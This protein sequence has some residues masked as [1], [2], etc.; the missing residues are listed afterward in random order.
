[1]NYISRGLRYVAGSDTSSVDQVPRLIERIKTSALPQDRRA[2][3]SK[4][5]QLAK[6]SPQRQVQVGELALKIIHAVLDQDKEYDETLKVTLDLLI[7]ICGTLDPPS[8]D[9]PSA[10]TLDAADIA[11]QNEQRI[12]DFEHASAKAAAT[13]VDM[14]LGLPNAALLIL[15]MLHNNDFYVKF[16]SIELLT[17]MAANSRETLQM[18]ILEAPQGVTRICDLLDD[19][20]RHVRSNAVLLLST[21]CEQSSEICKIIAYGGVLEKLFSLM[22]TLTAPASVNEFGDIDDEEDNLESAIVVQDVL[23]VLRNLIEGTKMTKTFLRDTGCLPR[24]VNVLSR[25]IDDSNIVSKSGKQPSAQIPSAGVKAAVEKQARKNLLIVIQCVSAIVSDADDETAQIKTELATTNLFPSLAHVVFGY[26]D[27]PDSEKKH[28]KG[29]VQLRIAALKTMSMLV[30]GHD[31]YRSI[32]SSSTYALKSEESITVQVAALRAMTKD[33]SSA[34]REAS[35][36]VLRESLTVDSALGLPSSTLLNALTG[37]AGSSSYPMSSVASNDRSSRSIS[38]NSTNIM[39]LAEELKAILVGWPE[40]ADASAVFYAASIISWVVERVQGAKERLLA[41]YVNGGALLPQII[42]VMGK[43]ER[44]QGPPEVRVALFSLACVWLHD[45][46]SAVSA[47]LSSAVH[48]PMLVEIITKTGSRGDLGEVHTKG[49]SAVLLGICLQATG[50]ESG[51]EHSSD[52]GFLS[53]G[54]GASV[55]IPRGTIADVIRNRIGITIFTECLDDVR[56]TKAFTYENTGKD[57][58]EFVGSLAS[59]E[60]KSGFMSAN[61]HLGHERWYDLGVKNV[62]DAVYASVGAKALDLIPTTDSSSKAASGVNGYNPTMNGHAVPGDLS[63]TQKAILEDS[64]RD[65]VLNSYKEFIRSQDENLNAARRQIEEL[66]SA[67]K[68]TQLELDSAGRNEFGSAEVSEM[69]RLREQNADLSAQKQVMETLLEEK[70]ADFAAL[71]DAYASLEEEQVMRGNTDQQGTD[72]T[73]VQQLRAQIP[74]IQNSLGAEIAKSSDLIRRKELLEDQLRVVSVELESANRERDLLRSNVQPNVV[75]LLQWRTRAEVAE[76][77]ISSRQAHLD[78]VISEQES[79]EKRMQEAIRQRDEATAAVQALNHSNERTLVELEELRSTR[80]RE[81]QIARESS[82]SSNAGLHQEIDY[83]K[84]QLVEVSRV[85]RAQSENN[86]SSRDQIVTEMKMLQE[87]HK[88]VESLLQQTRIELQDSKNVSQEWQKRAEANEAAKDRAV[89]ENNKLTSVARDLER[90]VVDLQKSITSQTETTSTANSRVSELDRQCAELDEIRHRIEEEANALRDELATRTEQSI[91]LSGQLYEAEEAKISAE[92]AQKEAEQQL[93][94]ALEDIENFRD[95]STREGYLD[96]DDLKSKIADLEEELRSTKELLAD[97]RDRESLGQALASDRDA[98]LEKVESLESEFVRFR[99]HEETL[100]VEVNE[101]RERLMLL[102]EAEEAKRSLTLQVVSLQNSL[103]EARER[104]TTEVEN[105]QA[106]MVEDT[107]KAAE[108]EELQVH[109]DEKNLR[110][111]ELEL[112][113]TNALDRISSESNQLVDLQKQLSEAE[114]LLS[115][116][117][118]E[119]DELTA[120]HQELEQEIYTHRET[121]NSLT[122]QLKAVQKSLAESEQKQAATSHELASLVDAC[123]LTEQDSTTLQEENGRLR[124]NQAQLYNKIRSLRKQREFSSMCFAVE[125]VVNE[126]VSDATVA[127]SSTW[128]EETTALQKEKDD[129]LRRQADVCQELELALSKLK[130]QPNS[131]ET[132]NENVSINLDGTETEYDEKEKAGEEVEQVIANPEVEKHISL[133]IKEMMVSIDHEEL[134]SGPGEEV[135]ISRD[136]PQSPT[137]VREL[138]GALRDAAKTVSATHI[139]LINAQALLVELSSDKTVMRTELLC[140]HEKIQE[141]ESQLIS[142]QSQTRDTT[143]AVADEG[144]KPSSP[145]QELTVDLLNAA[146]VEI[147][148][149]RTALK[150]SA[151]EADTAT[152]LLSH[153][154]ATLSQIEKDK[155]TLESSHHIAE[156]ARKSLEEEVLKLRNQ[157]STLLSEIEVCR[158]ERDTLS[159]EL[160]ARINSLE[161]EM[162]HSQETSVRECARLQNRVAEKDQEATAREKY[163]VSIRNELEKCRDE[164]RDANERVA[165]LSDSETKLTA[166]TEELE[167]TVVKLKRSLHVSKTTETDLEQSLSKVR[168]ELEKAKDTFAKEK[169]ELEEQERRNVTQLEQEVEQKSHDLESAER[170]FRTLE[171]ELHAS[172]LKLEEENK[173]LLTEA[174]T[175]TVELEAAALKLGKEQKEREEQEAKLSKDVENLE[176]AVSQLKEELASKTVELHKSISENSAAEQKLL[177]LRRLLRRAELDL[178]EER[179]AKEMLESENQ[180][181]LATIENLEGTGRSLKNDL[182]QTEAMMRESKRE[183]TKLGKTVEQNAVEI[184][185]TK[186]QL[187]EKEQELRAVEALKCCLEDERGELRTS[188]IEAASSR[189]AFEQDN[190][191]LRAWVTDLERRGTELQSAVS[192]FEEVEQSLREALENQ[193]ETSEHVAELVEELKSEKE[194]LAGADARARTAALEKDAAESAKNSAQKR[195]SDLE[196]RIREIR[197]EHVKQIGRSEEAIL[198]KSRRVSELE[199]LLGEKERQLAQQASMSDSLFAAHAELAQ[200]DDDVNALQSRAESAEARAEELQVIVA[201]LKAQ[202]AEMSEKGS[203]DALRA[204][205][206]EHNELLVC[207]ADLEL[208]CTLL[209]EQLGTE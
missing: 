48:L 6:Q 177:E 89:L 7:S 174:S 193:R 34:I 112:S 113:L 86:D 199:S 24:L 31:E 119:K 93:A 134:L 16:G 70:N 27:S 22:E 196:A 71:S 30:R 109:L 21:L 17:A 206:A 153:I 83:L 20:H 49:L 11:R 60:E 143:K 28:S 51:S 19:A 129:A 101:M 53:G 120:K 77:K 175:R 140:A 156:E 55:V 205:E 126:M 167:A 68:E 33:P 158:K 154:D 65:E 95:Q 45:S 23:I 133:P 52:G 201:G 75:E 92:Q 9:V 63:S 100:Q 172:I 98:A 81:L 151:A 35:C 5:T 57:L 111:E 124:E 155:M 194:A 166:E 189:D 4:L 190:S 204:L 40:H 32:F 80:K 160:H 183:C 186:A 26:D 182:Q 88:Q 15:E 115:V 157:K 44:E 104:G 139:E 107:S 73:E 67:L 97:S 145:S 163:V 38:S 122:S 132:L 150:R 179:S 123:K 10:E 43:V 82:A 147:D 116:L 69:R 42:R 79:L 50:I 135:K 37:S 180:D 118:S 141:L 110:L 62:V 96:A 146:N 170:R 191:D 208:E 59:T 85:Q 102:D 185:M 203:G 165:S 114:A 25:S 207:L 14:F 159:T 200:K 164:L 168:D 195:T 90:K 131:I 2:A 58:W 128:V 41:S 99:S 169:L 3:I 144:Q 84:S 198:S 130:P 181:F 138:E 162:S 137:R 29:L 197:Q 188:L 76:G 66:A 78:S 209:K 187:N 94:A 36:L 108:L 13:N 18:A 161:N 105:I 202:C 117:G 64:A 39:Y 136:P 61:G 12:K 125:N 56:A 74:I 103:S 106:K 178:K 121:A 87:E 176:R 54:G 152:S 127:T 148:N 91:R 8:L 149:L 192:N 47:F 142:Q 1:M 184:E 72:P 173:E 171:A 46:P